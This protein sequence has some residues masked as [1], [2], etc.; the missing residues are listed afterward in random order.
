MNLNMGINYIDTNQHQRRSNHAN[1][2]KNSLQVGH[3]C[4]PVY[5]FILDHEHD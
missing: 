4:S 3:D 5:H 2:F 1:F